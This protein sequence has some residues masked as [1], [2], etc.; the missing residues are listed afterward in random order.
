MSSDAS[1][2]RVT[3]GAKRLQEPGESVVS[4]R[5]L[6]RNA[7]MSGSAALIGLKAGAPP[8]LM[9]GD[10]FPIRPSAIRPLRRIPEAYPTNLVIVATEGMADLG[11][12]LEVPMYMLNV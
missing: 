5:E 11:G 7:T 9:A 8:L 6:V 3:E 10:P 12:R 2:P 4:R 1:S